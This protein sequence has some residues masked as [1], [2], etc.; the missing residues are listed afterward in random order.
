[1]LD[2]KTLIEAW[3]GPHS[4]A[5]IAADLGIKGD[6]LERAFRELKRN[7][8]LP[9]LSR[10]A[11]HQATAS[12][13]RPAADEDG[14]AALLELLIQHHGDDNGTGERADLSPGCKN[15][16]QARREA[17]RAGSAPLK[18]TGGLGPA[19]PTPNS[20]DDSFLIESAANAREG[21]APW[22]AA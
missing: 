5:A 13:D 20:A 22:H 8:K 4:T 15:G 12:S 10:Q 3:H 9:K 16:R 1:M 6:A 19:G 14:S 18:R 2:E 21:H 17:V 11:V 7:G